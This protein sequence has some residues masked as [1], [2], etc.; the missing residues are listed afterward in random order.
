[1]NSNSKGT[2]HCK[3]KILIIKYYNK[4]RLISK[5]SNYFGRLILCKI[6]FVFCKRNKQLSN[7]HKTNRSNIKRK[8]K[9]KY[10]LNVGLIHN[11]LVLVIYL[12]IKT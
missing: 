7:K 6:K 1:M 3:G 4:A 8:T 5:S 10:K 9:E 11:L 2:F 12:L